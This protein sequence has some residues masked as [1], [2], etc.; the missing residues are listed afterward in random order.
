MFTM[1]NSAYGD[2]VSIGVFHMIKH[3]VIGK[4]FTLFKNKK[5]VLNYL[6]KRKE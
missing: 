6:D 3:S 4:A 2:I 1:K 5:I